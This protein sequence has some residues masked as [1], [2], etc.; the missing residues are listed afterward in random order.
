MSTHHIYWVV[1]ALT[2][3]Y[4]LW[5]GRGD[6]RVA[7]AVCVL[8][9]LVTYFIIGPKLGGF[10]SFETGVLVVDMAAFAAFVSVA[11]SSSRF[12]PLWVAGLQLTTLLAHVFRLAS[13]DLIPVAYAAAGR[14]WSYPIL[15]ILVIGTWRHQ[16]RIRQEKIAQAA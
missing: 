6:E 1:L 8:A 13:S 7:A 5:R 3:G 16:R 11:L 9:S 2:C 4:A 15:L 12:W 14:F 10:Y